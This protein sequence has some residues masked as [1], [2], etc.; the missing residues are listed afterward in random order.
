MAHIFVLIYETI[1]FSVKKNLSTQTRNHYAVGNDT[2]EQWIY[3]NHNLPQYI[4]WKTL[5]KRHAM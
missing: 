1:T 5:A 2:S 3:N 4:D